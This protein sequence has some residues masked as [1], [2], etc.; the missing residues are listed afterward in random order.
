[1]IWFDYLSHGYVQTGHYNVRRVVRLGKSYIQGVIT[2]GAAGPLV[3]MDYINFSREWATFTG[4]IPQV[5]ESP[6]EYVDP[7]GATSD[8]N[9]HTAVLKTAL[10][11]I[12][13]LL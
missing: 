8:V 2:A 9:D 6:K 4:D 13:M 12:T 1:M 5:D 3:D 10:P 11:L 7:T